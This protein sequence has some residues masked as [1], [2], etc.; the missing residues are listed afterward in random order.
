MF[1]SHTKSQGL[2]MDPGGNASQKSIME[3]LDVFLTSV[4]S[5]WKSENFPAIG[6]LC[7][8]REK[9][10]T[11]PLRLTERGDRPRKELQLLYSVRSDCSD[12]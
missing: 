7:G 1:P 2:L 8:R 5:I 12:I 9:W 3:A 10:N 4:H 6:S 11:T